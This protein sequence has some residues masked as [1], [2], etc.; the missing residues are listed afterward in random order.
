MDLD[1]VRRMNRSTFAEGLKVADIQTL[2]DFGAKYGV[3][4]RPVSAAGLAYQP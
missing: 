2:L 4:A 3:I 1:L